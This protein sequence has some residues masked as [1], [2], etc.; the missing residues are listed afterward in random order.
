MAGSIKKRNSAK[1]V[2][3]KKNRLSPYAFACGLLLLSLFAF[4]I[5]NDVQIN[6]LTA[7]TT[8]LKSELKQLQNEKTK[9]NV[10][11]EKR[12]DLKEIELRAQ[13][14]LGLI[15]VNKSQVEYISLPSE[16]K[17]EFDDTT[18]DGI[19]SQALRQFSIILE[20]LS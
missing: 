13:T 18:S 4:K 5:Y 12:T 17:I 3:H 6:E 1:T 15:K 9:L 14:E 2:K 16:D 8:N 10:S 19:I 7:K 20:F 11:L